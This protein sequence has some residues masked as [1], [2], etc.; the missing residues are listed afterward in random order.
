MGDHSVE[1]RGSSPCQVDGISLNTGVGLGR[2]VLH[3]STAIK[4]AI[5]RGSL[6][7]S[8]SY[9]ELGRLHQ[10]LS[11]LVDEIKTLISRQFISKFSDTSSQNKYE[12]ESESRD[13][14]NVLSDAGQR[15]WLETPVN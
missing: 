9:G 8:L 11:E 15:S 4:S 10:A 3:P 1:N 7:S 13:I 5:D 6:R 12:S 14:L 2:A